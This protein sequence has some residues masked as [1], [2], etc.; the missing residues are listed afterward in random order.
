MKYTKQH[1][2]FIIIGVLLI[3]GYILM[4]QVPCLSVASHNGWTGK[5]TY[6]T[7]G[8][9]L[10]P[11]LIL[12]LLEI[13]LLLGRNKLLRILAILI[14]FA[15]IMLPWLQ[16]SLLNELGKLASDMSMRC[17]IINSV[18]YAVTALAVATLIF[19]IVML[20]AVKKP[21]AEEIVN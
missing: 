19:N 10:Q 21:R 5:T 2:V 6:R 18:P 9:G 16:L 20:F 3:A 4:C 8:F 11:Y 17:E 15:K 12:G 7:Q 13:L 1:I 14:A